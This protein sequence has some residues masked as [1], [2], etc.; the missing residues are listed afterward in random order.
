[1]K[2]LSAPFAAL[3]DVF[4][5]PD[6]GR[7]QLAWAGI[8][9]ATWAFAIALGVY[10]FD[11]A[12]TAAVGIASVVRILPGA[13]ASPFGGLLGDRYSRRAVLIGSTLGGAVV[14]ALATVAV[15]ADAPTWLVFLLGGLFTAFAAPYTPA[16]SALLPQLARTPQ[17]LS[18]ANV[19][20]SIMDNAGFL[21]GALITGLLLGV[22]SVQVAFGV[23][24]AVLALSLIVLLG[25]RRDH[26]PAYEDEED[27]QGVVHQTLAG[28][29]A[30]FADPPLRLLGA[31]EMWLAF[32]EG[33]ADV[34]VV[35]IALD[36]LGLANSSVGVLN[37]MWGIGAL[38]GS[39]AL[40]VLINR[41]QLVSGLVTGSLVIGATCA[42]PGIWPVT[43]AAV[44]SGLG[45]G[46]GY[47]FVDVAARTL[48]QR[49]G[50][51]EVLARAQGALESGRLLGMAVG[52][53]AM[54]PLVELFGIRATVLI[55]AA[56]MPLFVALRWRRLRSYEI[57]APVAEEHFALL[58]GEAIFAPLSL[59]TLERL[60]QDLIPVEA[61]PG[62][63][64]ITQGDQGDR[65]YIIESGEV[66]VFQDG[67]RRRSQHAGESF[68]EI[69]LLR[70]EPRTATVQATEPTQ[71][72]A[73]ERESFIAAVTGH[74]RS[75]QAADS[76]IAGRL[77]ATGGGNIDP[78]G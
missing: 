47:T 42:L 41:G 28:F 19:A 17:E 36:L 15:A 22:T 52:A 20:Q 58:R 66:E 64:V 77:T 4:R 9:F 10:A 53:A 27:V 44:L 38:V 67:N 18:A 63:E 13:L 73:L 3:G 40:A 35:L 72:L 8:A 45:L 6:L 16:E 33:A 69:A 55:V 25:I 48:F 39:A 54:A 23:A 5:N 78:P 11:A 12:G 62:Q 34:L 31:C 71:L 32:L 1:V 57:G 2:R 68:G 14:L 59:A 56:V 50:D 76:V 75:T 37:A 21:G 70:D 24:A 30:L 65:F 46:F 29:K 26:R 49:L 51:D 74:H 43:A 7:L 60:T 61:E